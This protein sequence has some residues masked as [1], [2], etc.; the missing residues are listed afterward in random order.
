MPKLHPS[1]S[2]LDGLFAQQSAGTQ[3]GPV[4]V[5]AFALNEVEGHGERL[6]ALRPAVEERSSTARL[7]HETLKRAGAH[8][9]G[10]MRGARRMF[11]LLDPFGPMSIVRRPG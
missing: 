8:K 7:A 4:D 9:G 11:D 5:A 6:G 10:T 3:A 1:P 2:D